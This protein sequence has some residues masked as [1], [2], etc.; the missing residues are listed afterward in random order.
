MMCLSASYTRGDNII[1]HKLISNKGIKGA[2]AA[3]SAG[4]SDRKNEI[5]KFRF[6]EA[7]LGR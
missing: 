3:I 4:L 2:N 6:A 7:M 5:E 1:F